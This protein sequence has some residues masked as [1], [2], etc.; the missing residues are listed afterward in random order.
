M[1]HARSEMR[2]AVFEKRFYVFGGEDLISKAIENS[3]E[4]YDP[5]LNREVLNPMIHAVHGSATA[6]FQRF[7]YKE[8]KVEYEEALSKAVDKPDI[9]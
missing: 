3:V 6:V 2:A 4:R 7:V 9:C 5:D 1:N 8:Q